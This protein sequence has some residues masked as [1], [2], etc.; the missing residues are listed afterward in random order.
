MVNQSFYNR[1]YTVDIIFTASKLF[2]TYRALMLEVQS[3]LL[4]SRAVQASRT[5]PAIARD[6]PEI[7]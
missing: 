7:E 1:I 5:P 3:P 2:K 6:F 4:T